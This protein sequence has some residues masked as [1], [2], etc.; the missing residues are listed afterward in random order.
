MN[1]KQKHFLQSNDNNKRLNLTEA[2][3]Q[4]VA[5]AADGP[6]NI[7]ELELEEPEMGWRKP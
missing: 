7:K 6:I 2:D 1:E 5:V 4:Q 3:C